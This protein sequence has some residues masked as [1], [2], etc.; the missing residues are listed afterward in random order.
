MAPVLFEHLGSDKPPPLQKRADLNSISLV[1]QILCFS[2][3]TPLVLLRLFAR[4]RLRYPLGAEDGMCPTIY[5][6]TS[7]LTESVTC[8]VAYV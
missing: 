2:I 1:T 6:F 5:I 8:Y 7:L 4:I 3:I